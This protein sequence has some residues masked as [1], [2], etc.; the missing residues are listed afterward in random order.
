MNIKQVY[1]LMTIFAI[2]GMYPTVAFYASIQIAYGSLTPIVGMAILTV[3][4]ACS[5]SHSCREF[6]VEER[7]NKQTTKRVKELTN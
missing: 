6:I 1:R 4:S 5:I 7:R 3:F 2:L